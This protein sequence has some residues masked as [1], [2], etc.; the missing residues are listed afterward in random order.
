MSSTF[1]RIFGWTGSMV[2]LL[3]AGIVIPSGA[4]DPRP[5]DGPSP[6]RGSLAPLGMTMP[7]PRRSTMLPVQPKIRLK[8][9]DI[10]GDAGIEVFDVRPGH[11]V[12]DRSADHQEISLV[13]YRALDLQQQ[14]LS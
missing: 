2:D 4:R 10:A 1:N 8:V 7:A 12:A 6:G 9:D 5:G 13:D 14:L 3:G 11:E